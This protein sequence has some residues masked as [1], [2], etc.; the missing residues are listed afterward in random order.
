MSLKSRYNILQRLNFEALYNT[1]L[2]LEGREQTFAL[3]GAGVLVLFLIGLPLSLASGKLSSLENQLEQGREKGRQIAHKLENYKQLQAQLKGLE[4]KIGG[5]FDPTLTTTMEQLAE[6]AGIKERI[7]NIKQRAPTPSDMY[8]E[9]SADV[10]LTRITVPQLVDYLYNIENDPG[11][12]LRI[13]QIQVKRRYDNK[14]LM[15]VSFQ[16]STYKLQGV[17]G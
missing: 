14:Q 9:V 4:V 7:E 5:G 2:G 12:F 10:R 11:H 17:G 3:I 15:D 8:D 1:F 13:R 16:V 6:K